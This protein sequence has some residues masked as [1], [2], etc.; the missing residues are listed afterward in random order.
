MEKEEI[1]AI[2]SIYNLKGI[3]FSLDG[4]NLFKRVDRY[5]HKILLIIIF[6]I[7]V[8]LNLFELFFNFISL[9]AWKKKPEDFSSNMRLIISFISLLNISATLSL[10]TLATTKLKIQ[11]CIFY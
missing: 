4:H 2:T 1:K 8:C 10:S 7:L 3:Y 9:T 11:S 5:E 6:S